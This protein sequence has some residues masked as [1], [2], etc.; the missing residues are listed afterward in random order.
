ME[1][2][3]FYE[4]KP[5]Q[6]CITLD[7]S[8][9]SFDSYTDLVVSTLPNRYI[10]PAIAIVKNPITYFYKEYNGLQIP[11]NPVEMVTFRT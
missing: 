10:D 9:P 2:F 11:L 3:I 8:I 5:R 1:I 4:N 7:T 6:A